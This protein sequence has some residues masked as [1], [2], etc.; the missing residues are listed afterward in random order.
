MLFTFPAMNAPGGLAVADYKNC[1][2]RPSPYTFECLGD[3]AGDSVLRLVE[4]MFEN[5][6]E[7]LKPGGKGK[8][9]SSLGQ[10]VLKTT[11][12]KYY[13]TLARDSNFGT[14]SRNRHNVIWLYLF[15]ERH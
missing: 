14:L 3:G 4:A 2:M 10:A 15:Y 13:S 5:D 12:N 6:V 11:K 9:Y 8:L 1:H 7:E